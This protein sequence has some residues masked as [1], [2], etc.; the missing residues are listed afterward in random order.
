MVSF[1]MLNPSRRPEKSPVL[2]SWCIFL[3]TLLDLAAIVF[4]NFTTIFINEVNLNVS[5]IIIKII[6]DL[7]K[8]LGS[9]CSFFLYPKNSV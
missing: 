7:S 3:N 1:L 2:S 6:L 9:F 5:G 8:E 4:R